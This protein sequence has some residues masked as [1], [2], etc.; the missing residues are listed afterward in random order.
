MA[1]SKIIFQRSNPRS[2]VNIEAL[3][4]L[5]EASVHLSRGGRVTIV[6]LRA[7]ARMLSEA[8]DDR[9]ISTMLVAPMITGSF[10]RARTSSASLVA[11]RSRAQARATK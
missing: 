10:V 3:I 1:G 5:I 8:D 11:P 2:R 4:A 7:L 9:L 6:G